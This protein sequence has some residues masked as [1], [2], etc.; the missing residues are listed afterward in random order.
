MFA[1]VALAESAEHAL[2][3]AQALWVGIGLAQ[4][5]RRLRV[6]MVAEIGCAFPEQSPKVRL[7]HRRGW[8][9]AR[10]RRFKCI[11]ARLDLSFDVAGFAAHAAE[12][13]KA[14]VV[15]LEL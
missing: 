13:F 8:V 3:E 15:R 14:I 1:G 10:T 11:S 7:F 6:R 2:L 4:V 5:C 12:I 9:C